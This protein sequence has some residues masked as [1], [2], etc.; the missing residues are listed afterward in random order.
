[1]SHYLRHNTPIDKRN[2]ARKVAFSDIAEERSRIIHNEFN[3]H[4]GYIPTSTHLALAPKTFK[5]YLPQIEVLD[6]Y[7]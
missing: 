2:E 6:I 1:M 5:E 4:G 7:S 3:G